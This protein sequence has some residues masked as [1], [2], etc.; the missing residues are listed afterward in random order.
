MDN[1]TLSAVDSMARVFASML[2]HA[3]DVGSFEGRAVDARMNACAA[4]MACVGIDDAWS[5]LQ[6]DPTARTPRP[7]R[8]RRPWVRKLGR[9]RD[10]AVGPI[11]FQ[12]WA[13]GVKMIARRRGRRYNDRHGFC[14][15]AR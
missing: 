14:F 10:R 11:D 1:E 12:G 7:H 15:R 3:S 4:A 8:L 13:R 5:A 2:G 9:Q 6:R